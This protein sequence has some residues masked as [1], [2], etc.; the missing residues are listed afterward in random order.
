MT[1]ANVIELLIG[2]I[3]TIGFGVGGWALLEVIRAKERIA[4]LEVRV[5]ESPDDGLRGAVSELK[6]VIGDLS[7]VV[8]RMDEHVR[9]IAKRDES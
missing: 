5:G 6:D 7:S 1:P 4:A 9:I 8:S 3:A 2:I